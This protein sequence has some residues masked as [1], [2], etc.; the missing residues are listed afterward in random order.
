MLKKTLLAA[1]VAAS[2][3]GIGGVAQAA[4]HVVITTAPPSPIHEVVPAPRRGYVWVPGHHVYRH[5]DYVWVSG[6][7]MRERRGYAYVAPRWEQR[8]DQWVMIGDRWERHHDR[9]FHGRRDNDRDGVPNRYDD[10]PN[11]PNRS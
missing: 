9:G 3:A 1:V 10:R 2:F 4:T 11:N 5:H 6:H 8:G 7:W